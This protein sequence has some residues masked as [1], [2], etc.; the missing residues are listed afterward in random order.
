MK[1]LTEYYNSSEL[2]SLTYLEFGAIDLK[3]SKKKVYDFRLHDEA[4]DFL[5]LARYMKDYI[6]FKNLIKSDAPLPNK[7]EK[8]GKDVHTRDI[9]NTF[10]KLAAMNVL[11]RQEGRKVSFT[12]LGSTLMGAIEALE[13][14]KK[15]GNQLAADFSNVDLATDI[16][17]I[18]IDISELLN[19]VAKD[20]HG[21]YQ[22]ETLINKSEFTAKT[23]I[24]FA[25]GVSILY[26]IDTVDELVDVFTRAKVSNFDYSFSL[27]EP[28]KIIIGSGK[29]VQ[30]L[31][32]VEFVKAFRRIDPDLD[33][34]LEE[35]SITIVE[36]GKRVRFN[37]YF[38]NKKLVDEIVKEELRIKTVFLEALAGTE[39]AGLIS[40]EH[41]NSEVPASFLNSEQ[42][43][44][45]YVNH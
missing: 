5:M 10:N 16:N 27:I 4:Y 23:D 32:I 17:Y 36:E 2:N 37:G 18:G 9:Y 14:V 43:L 34:F 40:W 33:L 13:F 19:S 39:H 15:E 41:R 26:A 31:N 3:N 45:R 44:D 24:F 22:L 8:Y 28:H 35:S 7:M 25:K 11:C 1:N 30:Y 42:F 6:V 21:D 20:L 12:E 38:G 29:N